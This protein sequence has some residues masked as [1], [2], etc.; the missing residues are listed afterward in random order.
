[1]RH[2][3]YATIIVLLFGC[4]RNPAGIEPEI[5]K[6][7]VYKGVDSLQYL[8]HYSNLMDSKW[9]GGYGVIFFTA[10]YNTGKDWYGHPE[11]DIYTSDVLLKTFT[12]ENFLG[13]AEGI[14]STDITGHD[15][16]PID[17]VDFIPS[18]EYRESL[19]FVP[20][21]RVDLKMYYY[22]LWSFENDTTIR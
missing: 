1:M 22:V 6:V 20:V 2:I 12:H 4:L 7:E 15:V 18:N 3:L 14:L 11:V 19:T 21:N 9:G 5:I 10:A 16:M 8:G 13:H 17:T